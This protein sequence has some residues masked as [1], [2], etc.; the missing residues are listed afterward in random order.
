MRKMTKEQD[1]YF[2]MGYQSGKN[3]MMNECTSLRGKINGLEIRLKDLQGLGQRR[4]EEAQIKI[5]ES[6]AM[7]S[8]AA[9]KVV[10]AVNK[11]L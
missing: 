9:S 1:K 3:S 6:M 11:C 7:I 4:Q 2:L 8:E 10:L 5:M